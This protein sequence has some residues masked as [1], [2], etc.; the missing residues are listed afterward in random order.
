MEALSRELC[1]PDST[2]GISAILRVRVNAYMGAVSL[3]GEQDAQKALLHAASDRLRKAVRGSDLV[4][5][6]RPG[7]FL[8]L[9]RNLNS[10]DDIPVICER[11]IRTCARPFYI[12]ESEVY[13]GF[14]VGASV[15]SG[16][17]CDAKALVRQVTVTMYCRNRQGESGFELFSNGFGVKYS[18]PAEVES[19][20]FEALQKDLFDLDYQPQYNGDGTLIGLSSKI[21]MRSADGQRLRGEAFLRRVE[22][23]DLILRMSDVLLQRL[24]MN[25]GDWLTKGFAVPSVCFPVAAPYFLQPAFAQKVRKFL[26]EADLPGSHLE[27]RLTEATIMTDLE[28]ARRTMVQLRKLGV[29]FVLDG[30]SPG[31][32]LTSCFPRVPIET[33]QIS[34]SPDVLPPD[35]SISLLTAI[36]S[37]ARHLGFRVTSRDVQSCAQ[38]T[39]LRG[40]GCDGFQGPLF[41]EPL[42]EDEIEEVLMIW[43]APKVS[44]V[45]ALL[46]RVSGL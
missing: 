4:A 5:R 8:I 45:S 46:K 30:I 37:R 41:S 26:Q 10:E 14:I 33:L 32:F 9:L 1:A 29:R 36:I 40:A 18:E 12:G 24:C 42:P 11:I 20:M 43:K 17:E 39:A 2:N 13:S 31:Q 3:F 28:T 6:S 19:C 7:I 16:M 27:L 23:R 22:D 15:V 21:R 44:P 35:G 38:W 34:C 25:A